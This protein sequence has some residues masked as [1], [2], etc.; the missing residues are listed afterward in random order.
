MRVSKVVR[1]ICGFSREVVIIRVE[2]TD[3]ARPGLV[4]HVRPKAA[5]EAVAV[6]APGQHRGSTTVV[7]SAAGATS[8]PGS[9]SSR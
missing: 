7:V 8:M 3:R 4:V 6:V 1:A 5:N 2:V 9:P